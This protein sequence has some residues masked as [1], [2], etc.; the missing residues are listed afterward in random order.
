MTEALTAFP[1]EEALEV[2]CEGEPL[3]AIL[4]RPAQGSPACN[5]AVL[6]VVGGPQYRA[7]SHRQFVQLA[8]ALALAGYP[9]L[10][11][12]VRGM[13]DSGG[14]PV[15][16]EQSSSDLG[17]A[18]DALAVHIPSARRFVLW[19]LCDGAS[20]A[21]LYAD[22]RSDGRVRGL[23][24]ANPWV[25]SVDSHARTTL[26]HY[27]A[28]RVLQPEFWRKLLRGKVKA[29]A[30]RELDTHVRAARA[31]AVATPGLPFHQRMLRGL[32][33]FDG[34][35]FLVLSGQD[36]TAREFTDRMQAE[37]RW[38]AALD[39][40]STT[41]ADFG[42]ADHTF[43]SQAAQRAVEASTVRWLDSWSSLR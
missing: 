14:A 34:E 4:H 42:D 39:R 1:P 19:G 16:F 36:Y 38:R 18:L 6:I 35:V 8:R 29:G 11:F 23:C 7:G 32:A 2:A 5:V 10:R 26:R 37:P 17:A 31:G 33:A 25:R 43:S 21:L 28:K 20:A 9:V 13:G 30:L 40:R 3:L 12:D 24:L 27:Y 41:R 15:T 22:E